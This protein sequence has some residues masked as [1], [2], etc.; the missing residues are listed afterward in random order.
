MSFLTKSSTTST[1]LYTPTA[2]CIGCGATGQIVPQNSSDLYP[3]FDFECPHCG[4]FFEVIGYDDFRL[5]QRN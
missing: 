1:T 5:N 2:T 3:D 4:Q